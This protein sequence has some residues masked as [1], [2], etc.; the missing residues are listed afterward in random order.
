VPK[1]GPKLAAEARHRIHNL[2]EQVRFERKYQNK[3][4]W[5]DFLVWE[6]PTTG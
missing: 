5:Y 4:F 3:Q 1:R 6:L 2:L